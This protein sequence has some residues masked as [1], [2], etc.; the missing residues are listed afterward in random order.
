VTVAFGASL[1]AAG[2][3]RADQLAELRAELHALDALGPSFVE[4][5][6]AAASIV[7]RPFDSGPGCV[8]GAGRFAVGTAYVEIDPAC[9]AGYAALRAAVGHEIGH[10]IGMAH[11]CTYDGE[12]PDC[13]PVGVGFA[14]MNPSLSYGDTTD[15][16]STVS[17]IA[18]DAPTDLDLAEY[19]RAH[20]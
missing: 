5:S 13:S 6:E 14:M 18:S 16:A 12:A 9:A 3:W 2:P 19:R 11:V 7:V 17:D 8:R 4:A 20:P 15:P 1:D 10:A